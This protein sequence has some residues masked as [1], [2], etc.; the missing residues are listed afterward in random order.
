MPL[1]LRQADMPSACTGSFKPWRDRG[2]RLAS[3]LHGAAV[4]ASET[5]HSDLMVAADFVNCKTNLLI[6]AACRSQR[7][8]A[9]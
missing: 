8:H 9:P 6:Q 4:N 7:K 3:T 2:T 5:P 1:Q